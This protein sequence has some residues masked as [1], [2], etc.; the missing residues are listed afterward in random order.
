M[1]FFVRVTAFRC[2]IDPGTGSRQSWSGAI[3]EDWFRMASE[4]DDYDS[5][6]K[7]AL[8]RYFRD[9]MRFFFPAAHDEI[10]WSQ[11]LAF[12]DQELQAVAEDG[13]LGRR[14]LDKLVRV[15]RLGGDQRRIYVHVEVEGN[16]KRDFEERL[17][18]CNCRLAGLYRR[19]VAS[20]VILADGHMDWRPSHHGFDVFGCRLE[21]TFPIVKLL[22][23]AGRIEALLADDNPFGLIVAAHLL[24]RATRRDREARYA[25]KL[26]LIRILYERGWDRERV[27]DLL[28]IIDW[29]MRLP[30]DLAKRMRRD[31][32][33]IEESMKMR[34]VT[35]FERLAKE[36]GREEGRL[37]GEISILKR[38][39]QSRFGEL[40]PWAQE[41]LDSADLEV[42][43]KWS[44]RLLA[45]PTL[46]DALR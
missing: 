23:F 9:F 37:E 42:V 17:F 35:S 24:T 2:P 26:K 12:L 4:R 10:D 25:A 39:L 20:L 45:A 6:W 41:R 34:Y 32:A 1:G 38:L 30:K 40:P 7:I 31:V 19:P 8:E 13:I 46:E 21:L 3:A 22:D 43:T 14:H 15:M 11:E 27:V 33:A 18:V 44:N 16:R 36:E 29:M 28:V 5:P